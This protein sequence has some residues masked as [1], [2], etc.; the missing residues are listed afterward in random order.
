[1]QVE[2]AGHQARA[3]IRADNSD[4]DRKV[5]QNQQTS[6]EGGSE[7]P[8]VFVRESQEPAPEPQYAQSETSAQTGNNLDISV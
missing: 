1:M 6:S 3:Y 4:A 7:S 5:E 2:T 8:T